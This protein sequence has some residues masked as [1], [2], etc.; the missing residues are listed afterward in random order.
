VAQAPI[1]SVIPQPARRCKSPGSFATLTAIPSRL[2]SSLFIAEG[3]A[4]LFRFHSFR[5]RHSAFLAFC[6]CEV[7]EA[8]LFSARL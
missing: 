1:V 2:I 6:R 7:P 5:Q 4:S 3:L 8:Y